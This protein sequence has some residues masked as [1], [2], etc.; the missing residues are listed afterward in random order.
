MTVELEFQG[1]VVSGEVTTKAESKSSSSSAPRVKQNTCA[2]G[3]DQIQ[4]SPVEKHASKAGT[5]DDAVS[6]NFDAFM[7]EIDALAPPQE[8]KEDEASK[9]KKD[10]TRIRSLLD[11]AS[12]RLRVSKHR[13]SV[14]V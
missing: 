12:G 8:K 6:A 11:L 13:G 4:K 14:C 3:G 10:G 7:A 2:E 9:A 5:V 1:P